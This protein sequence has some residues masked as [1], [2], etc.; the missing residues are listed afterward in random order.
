MERPQPTFAYLVS[1][2]RS[3]YPRL[4]YIHV[5]EPRVAAEFDRGVAAYESNDF[6]RAIWKGPD[7]E[8]N[9]SVFLSAGG[10]TPENALKDA[11][12]KGDLIVFGRHYISNVSFHTY[13]NKERARDRLIFC[14][15]CPL[16]YVARPSG[17]DKEGHSFCTVRS[18]IFL[19]IQSTGRIR[20]LSLRRFGDGGV[21]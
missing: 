7:S 17:K 16:L 21:V 5:G 15:F 18:Q 8:K 11:D 6:L 3:Q 12:E 13:L 2:I 14:Y 4:S 9:G 10:Y 1:L 20:R 19:R